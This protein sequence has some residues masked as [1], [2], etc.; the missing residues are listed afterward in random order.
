MLGT[1]S[2]M[3]GTD[4]TFGEDRYPLWGTGIDQVMG[5][6]TASLCITILPRIDYRTSIDQCYWLV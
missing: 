3:S 5:K 6:N 1:D 2:P 4:V